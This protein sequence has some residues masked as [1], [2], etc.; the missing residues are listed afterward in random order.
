MPVCRETL[1]V[2]SGTRNA[3]LPVCRCSG[4]LAL[5]PRRETGLIPHACV[6]YRYA[7]SRH[8]GSPVH[9]DIL[10]NVLPGEQPPLTARCAGIPAAVYAGVPG[11]R[12]SALHF[13]SCGLSQS[14]LQL[15]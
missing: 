12:G 4:T 6:L 10:C 7:G 5:D 3:G 9:R 11:H 1:K 15:T 14:L 2:C 8:A 13:P